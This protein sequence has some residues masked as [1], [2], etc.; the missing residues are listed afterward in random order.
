MSGIFDGW[1]WSIRAKRVPAVTAPVT[2]VGQQWCRRFLP[3]TAWMRHID[4]SSL[5]AD[6][7]A[8]L[9]GGL[10]LVPQGVAFALV[11]GMPPAYG[12]YTAIVPAIVAALFGSSM[13]LVS[14]PTTA[15]SVVVLS[16]LAPLATPGSEE[17]V[18]LA[19]TL[20]CLCGVVMLAFGWLRLGSLMNF[21]SH[22]V[23]V[24]FTAG[25]AVIICTSQFVNFFGL[26][27]PAGSNC[28]RVL[29]HFI[30]NI[31]QVNVFVAGVAA[32]TLLVSA[33]AQRYV[34]RGLHVI[35]ALLAGSMLA[36][37]L[38]TWL[39]ADRTG[40]VT[41]A[42]LPPGLPPLTLPDL[43]PDTVARLMPASLAISA[44]GLT[45]ALSIAR[46]LALKTG[47]RIDG[48]QECIGQGLSNLLGAFFSS[49]PSSGSFNRSGLNLEAGARTPLA[50]IFSALFLLCVIPVFAPLA[51]YL[52]M[53]AMA[54]VLFLVA[55]GLIDRRY[56]IQIL[57][58]SR[59]ESLVLATTFLS[60]ICLQL[61]FAIYI[62][63]LLSLVLYL[64]RTS[65]PAIED[66]KPAVAGLPLF[67]A[68]TGLDDCPQL[69]IL[70]VNGSLYFGAI[71]HAQQ[72]MEDV[73]ART[74]SQKFLALVCSGVNFID[75][76][77][78]QLLAQEALR[79]RRIGGD[80]FLCNVREKARQALGAF[81]CE[82]VLGSGHVFDLSDA[83]PIGTILNRLDSR[84]CA[85]CDLRIFPQCTVKVPAGAQPCSK[86]GI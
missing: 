52:P 61:E 41:L 68:T 38:N 79:R 4:Q 84:A 2:A 44:L 81:G 7:I 24:G 15:I 56:I 74:P 72:V 5:R 59:Q 1:S 9:A 54:G 70:R 67:S 6:L 13:H 40:I 77:G 42:A 60:T 69:K 73:D 51:A 26:T 62:G 20:S 66:V 3:F 27:I 80:L 14:G 53:P 22:T 47:Q 21:V 49:Y 86:P 57:R 36:V 8:G 50:V 55:W 64:N 85:C 35:V 78:A 76:A 65:H 31:T 83:D 33:V 34:K 19:L 75:M 46:A 63:V 30:L 45:E 58:S 12:L 29:Q 43:A 23:V 18:R 11:A 32:A 25:A 39:G 48:N 16:A 28:L 17:F 82:D 37:L 10:V 71:D